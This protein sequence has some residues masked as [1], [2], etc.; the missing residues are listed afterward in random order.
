MTERQLLATLIALHMETN[1]QLLAH[2]YISQGMTDLAIQAVDDAA[3]IRKATQD[4][5][6]GGKLEELIRAVWAEEEMGGVN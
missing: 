2:T 3:A 5:L 1:V 6:P 4:A